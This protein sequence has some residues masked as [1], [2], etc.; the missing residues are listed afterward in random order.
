M[1]IVASGPVHPCNRPGCSELTRDR[2]CEKCAPM[3]SAAF[4]RHAG[5]AASRGYDKRWSREARAFLSLPE[6]ALCAECARQG[7]V[8]A[9]GCV[10]HV[11]PWRSGATPDE[12]ER[13]RWDRGNWQPL[14]DWRSPFNCHG[15]KTAREAQALRDMPRPPRDA[16]DGMGQ[17][18]ANQGPRARA[19]R[20]GGSTEDEE[21]Q[22]V[23]DGR[24]IQEGDGTPQTGDRGGPSLGGSAPW[25]GAPDVARQTSP[26]KMG[27]P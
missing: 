17:M 22:L 18:R 1:R 3:R 21:K 20:R 16:R 25:T 11:T 26:V 12:Q 27:V 8:T 24:H 4:E 5:S 7:R 9:A 13:L 23:R 2:F 6:N 10:D 14:C 15:S 19:P